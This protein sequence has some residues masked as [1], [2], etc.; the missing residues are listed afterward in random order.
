MRSLERGAG[1]VEYSLILALV[2]MITIGV[3]AIFGEGLTEQYECV[4]HEMGAEVG[5]GIQPVYRYTLVDPS[6]DEEIRRAQCGGKVN[7][8]ELNFRADAVSTA[9]SVT[10]EIEGP[11]YSNTRTENNRPFAVFGN[12]GGNYSSS[13]TLAPGRYKVTATTDT[14]ESS[15]FFFVVE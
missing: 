5:G 14:G 1:L 3:L 7:L 2:A 10:F 4:V 11:G 9:T 12:S 15:R 6:T 13:G 8:T